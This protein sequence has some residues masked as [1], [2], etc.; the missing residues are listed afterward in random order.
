MKTHQIIAL[1]LV[2][3]CLTAW[4]VAGEA[5]P[6]KP[7]PEDGGEK[8][9]G[10]GEEKPQ[11]PPAE[12]KPGGKKLDPALAKPF[13]SVKD[14]IAKKSGQEQYKAVEEL[15]AIE[16]PKGE[17]AIKELSVVLTLAVNKLRGPRRHKCA[18]LFTKPGD[19]LVDLGSGGVGKFDDHRGPR[20]SPASGR[21]PHAQALVGA[22]RFL[23]QALVGVCRFLAQALVTAASIPGPADAPS[24]MPTAGPTY[25]TRRAPDALARPRRPTPDRG[26]SRTIRPRR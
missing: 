20:F 14:R 11:D 8:K 24:R 18:A 19:L 21:C 26:S 5:P 2:F 17:A 6:A 22:C 15:L 9:E 4:G 25:P 23:A 12:A 16:I 1:L 13:K 10:D 3:A 7:N